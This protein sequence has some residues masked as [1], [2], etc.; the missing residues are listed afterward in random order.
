MKLSAALLCIIVLALDIA[1]GILGIHAYMAQNQV[2]YVRFIFV[3][4]RE[5]SHPAFQ[6]GVA[7]A[8]VLLIAHIIANVGG[9]CI[10]YGSSEELRNSL[11][12]RQIAGVSHFLAW[13]VL[14]LGF[15][16]LVIGAMSNNHSRDT[17]SISR[18]KFLWIGG[19]L[20]FVHGAVITVYYITA[21]ATITVY[22]DIKELSMTERGG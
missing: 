8:S 11:V 17:C 14:G 21:T 2:K 5:P 9:G 22:R 13:I 1:A 16:F 4:C 12:N 19:M 15:G 18:H 6:L 3:E 20:C 10:C 7:A